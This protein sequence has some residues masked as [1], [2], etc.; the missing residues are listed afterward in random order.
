[1]ELRYLDFRTSSYTVLGTL[2][3]TLHFIQFILIIS[4]RN[5]PTVMH[6]QDLKDVYK[7][8]IKS[9]FNVKKVLTL[10]GPCII[11]CNIYKF[12]RDTQ[13]SCTA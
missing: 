4:D 3:K 10:E 5:T 12:Q 1:M 6:I 2:R 8:K 7:K 9:E 11:F 13:C